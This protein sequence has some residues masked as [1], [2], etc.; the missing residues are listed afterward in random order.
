MSDKPIIQVEHLHKL[1]RIGTI[2]SGTL[3]QDL[4]RWWNVKMKGRE[5]PLQMIAD[6]DRGNMGVTNLFWALHDINFTVKPGEVL[7]LIGKNGAGKSTLLKILSRVT[8]PTKGVIKGRGKIS[9][10]LEVG[11]GFHDELTGRE[12]IYLNGNILGLTRKQ[13][14]RKLDEIIAFSGVEPYIDTP[15]KR[16]SSGMYVRLAFSVAAHLE[17][18][19]LIVDEVL[20]VGDSEFQ[21]KCLGKMR[22]VSKHDGRTILFVSHSMQAVQSFCQ[23]VLLLDK[24]RIIHEGPAKDVVNAYLNSMQRKDLSQE[25]DNINEAPGND[26]IRIKRVVVEPELNDPLMP[27]D[28][29][30]P[31]HVKFEC[32]NLTDRLNLCVGVHLFTIAGECIFDVASPAIDVEK[33]IIEGHC[34]I[35]G[36][37]LNDGSYY[38]SLI[39]VKN[40]SEQ[41]YYHEESVSFDVEDFRENIDWYGKWIGYVRP[42]FPFTL[43]MKDNFVD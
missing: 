24:G 20:A 5:D 18:D 31:L 13:I 35:P 40:T 4:S 28:I 7:G 41:L 32:W 2:G 21:K 22:D 38:I 14:D 9:S 26:Y 23:R 6:V 16:Y 11:T 36:N 30:T 8:R 33:G 37:F 3:K 34:M 25:Y 15:V 1:Y 29:R 43:K 27:I 42:K 19:I 12:N 17:P 10:L 39:F